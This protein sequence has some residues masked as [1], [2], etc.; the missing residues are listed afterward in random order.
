MTKFA[1]RTLPDVPSPVKALKELQD[2]RDLF[3]IDYSRPISA[4][5][6]SSLNATLEGDE[7]NVAFVVEVPGLDT[8]DIKV[9][10]EGKTI[11][12]ETPKGVAYTTI[13]Q[14]ISLDEAT[15][16]LKRGVLTI[17]IPKRDAKTVEITVTEE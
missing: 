15:A 12:V 1:L 8:S 9:K 2:L 3:G 14:R 13:G 6:R 16:T 10:V 5:G 17:T 11:Y 7:H 4:R